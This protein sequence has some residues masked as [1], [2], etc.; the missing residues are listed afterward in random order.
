MKSLEN[1]YKLHKYWLNYT[2]L[3]YYKDNNNFRGNKLK[4][5]HETLLNLLVENGSIYEKSLKCKMGQF[6]VLEKKKKRKLL[7]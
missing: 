5:K 3:Q 2:I 1:G 7:F 6:N 4:S